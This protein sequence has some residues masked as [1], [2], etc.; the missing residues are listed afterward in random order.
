MLQVWCGVE[1]RACQQQPYDCGYSY[2]ALDRVQHLGH[3]PE[4]SKSESRSIIDNAIK[5]GDP[6]HVGPVSPL[7]DFVNFAKLWHR[8]FPTILAITFVR[9]ARDSKAALMTNRFNLI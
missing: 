3:M 9:S 4:R 5:F 7:S 2:F 8:H 6:N 1:V